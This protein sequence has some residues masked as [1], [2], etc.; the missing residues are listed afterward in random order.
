V[1]L[2]NLLKEQIKIFKKK[3]IYGCEDLWNDILKL[4]LHEQIQYLGDIKS[5]SIYVNEIRNDKHRML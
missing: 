2:T 3:G 1:N 5:D 4:L